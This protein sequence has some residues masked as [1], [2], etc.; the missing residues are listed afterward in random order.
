VSIVGLRRVEPSYVTVRGNDNEPVLAR[1][2]TTGSSVGASS[3]LVV[4]SPFSSRLA[5]D[6]QIN[7]LVDGGR[8]VVVV[9]APGTGWSDR[10]RGPL[11]TWLNQVGGA[12]GADGVLSI[13]P[14]AGADDALFELAAKLAPH[15]SG[16][17]VVHAFD[18]VRA[19]WIFSPWHER[20]AANRRRDIAVPS[21][22]ALH[23]ATLG[24]L[25]DPKTLVE[26]G[27][28]FNE[29]LDGVAFVPARVAAPPALTRTYV[30]TRFGFVHVSIDGRRTNRPTLLALHPSPGSARPYA[31][32]TRALSSGRR[33]VAPDM[34]GN[35]ASDL[36]PSHHA[37]RDVTF[38]GSAGAAPLTRTIADYAD[39]ALATLDALGE[40]APVDVWGNHTGALIGL[41][42]AIRHPHRVRKLVIDGLTIF[43][44]AE[45]A[46]ILAKYLPPFELDDYGGHLVRAWGM[47]HDM[48]LFWPW[49]RT[50]PEGARAMG[51]VPTDVLHANT[52]EL[53]RSGPSFRIAYDSAFRYPTVERL[54]LVTVPT[55]LTINPIDPLAGA[56]NAACRALP[57]MQ[58]A[59]ID[60]YGPNALDASVSVIARFLDS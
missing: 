46:D 7:A 41:E 1:V 36:P 20:T 35:G 51:A 6:E 14:S 23:D 31:H 2:H 24:L 48:A 15:P 40:D 56:A 21:A 12:V 26:R 32:V 42:L 18:A 52:M 30:H 22:A 17:H 54:P 16:V 11:G 44:A 45:T 37:L 53:L 13:G 43:D 5:H 34:L 38:P 60:G 59:T 49:Y 8:R 33:V 29:V 50:S 57:S 39:E 4:I 55:L 28:W 58:R 19:A 10:F 25:D 27:R 3:V 9:D 47:R